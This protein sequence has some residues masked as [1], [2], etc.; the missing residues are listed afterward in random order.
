MKSKIRALREVAA[1][2]EM[3]DL[4]E[5]AIH[6]D[7]ISV[8][9]YP[10]AA[11][12]ACGGT[13]EQA[14]PGSAAV[15]CSVVSIHLVDDMLDNDPRGDYHRLGVGPTANLALAFQAAGHRLLD[16]PS[17]DPHLRAKLQVI[18]AGMSLGT[19]YGQN[20]DAKELRTEQEYW[21]TVES[22]T[23]PLF[24]AALEMG[25]LLGGASS[26]VA[27]QLAHFGHVLGLFVQVSDDLSDALQ[28][29]ARADWQKASNNLP[30]LYAMTAE[31]AERAEFQ[32]LVSRVDDPEALALAQKILLRCGAVSYCVFK[33]LEFAR[34]ARSSLARIPLENPEPVSRLLD[35]H[36]K[37]LHKLFESVGIEEPMELALNVV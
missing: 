34:E 31:H 30:L 35:L 28:V 26:Q 9:D 14:L 20:L 27:R 15:F 8:W 19:A 29:P 1:W 32:Q 10:F 37:P 16:E 7:W 25:A 6:R 3:S 23:P 4:A 18:F 24:A 12:Q 22:K 36:M 11:C 33:L 2:P 13:E 21:R 17:I 5:R